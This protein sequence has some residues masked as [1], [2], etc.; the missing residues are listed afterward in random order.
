MFQRSLNAQIRMKNIKI[1]PLDIKII[2]TL[3]YVLATSIF[4]YALVI[5]WT[6]NEAGLTLQALVLEL[7]PAVFWFLFFALMSTYYSWYQQEKANLEQDTKLK[8]IYKL[9]KQQQQCL[10][11]ILVIIFLLL[12]FIH[13]K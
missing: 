13:P 3:N 2:N 7:R 1:H 5:Y 12:M 11:F 6:L 9:H 8:A 4:F 10:S